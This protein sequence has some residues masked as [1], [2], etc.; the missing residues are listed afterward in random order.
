MYIF[1]KTFGSCGK[2]KVGGPNS[3]YN[4][5]EVKVN[6]KCSYRKSSFEMFCI[7][8]LPCFLYKVANRS[9]RFEREC[10]QYK[11]MT[12]RNIISNTNCVH[13]PFYSPKI[14]AANARNS[15]QNAE[16]KLSIFWSNKSR[17]IH[18]STIIFG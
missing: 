9:R 17:Q 7:F 18:Y 10:D 6:Q 13:G 1:F 2:V 11:Q 16:E 14:V 8:T 4:K 3:N 15:T 12:R 5:K